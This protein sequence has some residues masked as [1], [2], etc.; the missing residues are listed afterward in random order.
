MIWSNFLL[1]NKLSLDVLKI[2]TMVVGS[3]SKIRN[4]NCY[5][6]VQIATWSRPGVPFRLFLNNSSRNVRKLRN[7]ET[8][9]SLPFR[10]IN[11]GQRAISFR[12]PN[13][14]KY[15]EID[16]KQLENERWKQF[17]QLIFGL[18]RQKWEN[19]EFSDNIYTGGPWPPSPPPATTPLSEGHRY[20]SGTGAAWA[21]KC[22]FQKNY[23]R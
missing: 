12:G 6:N 14:W 2:Q 3:Q 13:L 9:L 8:D 5:Y 1:G 7:T 10:K 15:L 4:W 23:F 11:N 18:F 16:V 17:V 19:N 20:S 21:S 22:S